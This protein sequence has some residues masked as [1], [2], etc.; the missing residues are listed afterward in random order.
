MMVG[1]ASE[2]MRGGMGAVVI[3][4]YLSL[5]FRFMDTKV[6]KKDKLRHLSFFFPYK[7]VSLCPIREEKV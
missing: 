4:V 3:S 6:G 1:T 5:Y 2:P 7:Y